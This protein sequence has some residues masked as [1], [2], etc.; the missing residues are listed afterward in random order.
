MDTGSPFFHTEMLMA[1]PD[2]ASD[3]KPAN[4]TKEIG[5][6]HGG[7]YD[8]LFSNHMFQARPISDGSEVLS[9]NVLLLGNRQSGRSSVGNALIGGE[10]FETRCWASDVPGTTDRRSRTFRRFFRRKG[11]E[12]DLRLVV[13]D[14]PPLPRPSQR[15]PAACTWV[16]ESV[17]VLLLVVRADLPGEDAQIARFAESLGGPG[18]C[19]H[20]VLVLTHADCLKAAGLTHAS[21]LSQAPHWL[22]T[23]ADMAG[24]GAIYM[25]NS[26]DWPVTSGAPLRERV[27]NLSAHNHHSVLMTT[28][29]KT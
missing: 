27:L 13:T 6:R 9:L 4:K 5:E 29:L 11:A 17:H 18:W 21:Y 25:D 16:P 15:R 24:G 28:R 22:R 8:N 12:T 14:S 26:S 10:E 2:S 1:E 20:A 23:L 3:K 19:H 7:F